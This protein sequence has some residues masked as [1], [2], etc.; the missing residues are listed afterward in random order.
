MKQPIVWASARQV[1]ATHSSTKAE[2]IAAGTGAKALTWLASLAEELRIQVVKRP[3]SLPIGGKP[4][5]KYHRG[6]IMKD[7]RQDVLLLTDN[8]RAFDIAHTNSLSKRTKHLVVRNHY[9]QQ[10]IHTKG[11]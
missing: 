8:K 2:F 9:T 4:A 3:V 1:T 10:K 6:E 5:T 11:T 7:D